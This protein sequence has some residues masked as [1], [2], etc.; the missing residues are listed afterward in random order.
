MIPIVWFVVVVVLVNF[1]GALLAHALLREIRA[2]TRALIANNSKELVM[3]EKHG[4]ATKRGAI[5]R[6]RS[7]EAE[8]EFSDNAPRV[9][10]L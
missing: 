8:S 2:L 10:G 3:L 9:M 1:T 6:R 7:P 5:A 4:E